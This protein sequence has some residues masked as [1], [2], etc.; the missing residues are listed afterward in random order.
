MHMSVFAVLEAGDF[1]AIAVI[2]FVVGGG[3][4]LAARSSADVRRLERRVSGLQVRLDA[5]LKHFGVAIPSEPTGLTPEIEEMARDP[6]QKIAA[7]KL[8]RQQNPGTSLA[9]A[10]ER[11]EAIERGRP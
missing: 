1:A 4:A 10:K 7:I 2:A 5:L 11:I 6:S 3:V 9:D 8:Y